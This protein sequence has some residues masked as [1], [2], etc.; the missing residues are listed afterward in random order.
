VILIL[1]VFEEFR[2][3]ATLGTSIEVVKSGAN[4]PATVIE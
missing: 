2:L 4:L 3:R 1:K